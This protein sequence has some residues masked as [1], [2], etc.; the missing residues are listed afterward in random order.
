VFNNT[1]LGFPN[2]MLANMYGFEKKDY[3]KAEETAKTAPKV[4]F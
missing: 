4:E 3:F 2:N 1:V